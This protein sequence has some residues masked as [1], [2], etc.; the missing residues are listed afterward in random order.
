MK[1]IMKVLLIA[2]VLAF[3]VAVPYADAAEKP[4]I[5]MIMVDNNN[6]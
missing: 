6:R 5:L 4:N 2:L 3:A 1:I